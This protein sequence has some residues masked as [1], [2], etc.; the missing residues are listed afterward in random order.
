[1]LPV[2]LL[3]TA[4]AVLLALL[5]F[6]AAA[7]CGLTDLH[8]RRR[9]RPGRRRVACVGDSIT[10]GCMIPFCHLRSYPAVLGRLLGKGW[11]IGNFG[12]NDRDLQPTGDKPYVREKDFLR[13]LTFEPEYVILLLGTNDS[14]DAN[15][16]SEEHFAEALRELA[17][18]YADAGA[19][20][21]VCTPPPAWAPVNALARLS[22]DA[23]P[24]RLPVIAEVIRTVCAADGL[25][26]IDLTKELDGRRDLLC[27]DALH[28]NAA[29]ARRFAELAAEALHRME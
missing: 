18:R 15:W 25:P 27:H 9:P 22:N 12:L 13:S 1:M 8:F 20:V 19:Q 3:C 6:C 21:I 7:A 2:I 5:I 28:L 16:R 14:K 26:L 10:N 24:E 17:G 11:Q 4:G 23:V 29:G